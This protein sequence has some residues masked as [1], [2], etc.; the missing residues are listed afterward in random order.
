MSENVF[1]KVIAEHCW[2]EFYNMIVG[3]VVDFERVLCYN[4][5]HSLAINCF[6]HYHTTDA[7]ILWTGCNEIVGGIMPGEIIAVSLEI[8]VNLCLLY[9]SPSPRDRG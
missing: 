8:F 3:D 7:R 9:T 1:E 6:Y 2:C 4:I 5:V